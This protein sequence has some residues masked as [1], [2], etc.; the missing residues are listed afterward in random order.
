MK[1][2]TLLWLAILLFNTLYQLFI[3]LAAENLKEL[4]FG[5][6]WLW[7]A[8]VSPWM[9]AALASEVASFMIWMQILARQDLG[10]AFPISGISYLLILFTSWI[11]FQEP[12][13]PL[14]IVGSALILTGVWLIGSASGKPIE[15]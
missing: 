1:R 7:Q 4:D 13:M 2:L 5:A 10:K 6:A 11:I 3:K 14:Q 15:H 8:A 9:L 12:V